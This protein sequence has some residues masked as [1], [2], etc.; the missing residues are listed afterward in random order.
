MHFLGLFW[1][2]LAKKS[3]LNFAIWT[4]ILHEDAPGTWQVVCK[5]WGHWPK[6]FGCSKTKCPKMSKNAK[7][8]TPNIMT[9]S[10]NFEFLSYWT[11][12]K[13]CTQ[14]NMLMKNKFWKCA[15]KYTLSWSK[16]LEMCLKNEDAKFWKN[17]KL[18][19]EKNGLSQANEIFHAGTCWGQVHWCQILWYW[20]L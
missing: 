7:F 10:S 19:F 6:A 17:S 8:C 9:L 16:K 3:N 14:V 15:S 2:F 4:E 11:T 13:F 20:D 12:I 1:V 5:I 18:N